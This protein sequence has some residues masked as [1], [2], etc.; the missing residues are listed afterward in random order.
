M[1]PAR[2]RKSR[3]M[4]LLVLPRQGQQVRRSARPDRRSARPDRT[5]SRVRR[6][7]V[8][9]GAASLAQVAG[10]DSTCELAGVN[11]YAI[12]QLAESDLAQIA[13]SDSTT[14]MRPQICGSAAVR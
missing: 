1:V 8:L 13:E 10:N 12:A 14:E 2:G 5:A 7:S 6:E 11:E 4:P 3:L 9:P